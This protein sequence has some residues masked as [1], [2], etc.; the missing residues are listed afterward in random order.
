MT[1]SAIFLM[2][3][4]GTGKTDVAVQLAERFPVEL[5]SVDSALVY[6]GLDIGTAKPSA[7]LRARVVHHLI[8]VCEP[9]ERYSVGTFL[10]DVTRVMA[11]IRARGRM[12]LLVGGTMLYFRAL[13]S[14]LAQLPAADPIVRARLSAEAAIEGWPAL[15][16]TLAAIDPAAHARIQPMDGQRIQRALE[17][18]ELTGTPLSILQQQDLRKATAGHY[19]KLVLAP[20]PRTA[21]HEALAQRFAGMLQAGLV[22]EVAGLYARGD[23]ESSLPAMRAVGYRQ[24]WSHVAEGQSLAQSAQEA[25]QATCQLAKRQG[26]WLRAEPDAIVVPAGTGQTHDVLTNQIREWWPS[27]QII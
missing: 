12:P 4:T 10:T 13:Q 6:R 2:G 26:T 9:T 5:V 14:G 23:L 20:P 25:I 22:D 27:E 15:H 24:L 21:H 18:F 3:A 16:A 1:L 7:A 8:D 17:V 19:L 11:D